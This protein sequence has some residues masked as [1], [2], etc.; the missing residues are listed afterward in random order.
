M[1]VI[2]SLTKAPGLLASNPVLFVPLFV[3]YLLSSI[4]TVSQSVAPLAGAI[5][6]LVMSGVLFFLGP[7]F[8]AGTI[9]MTNEAA[10]SS[11]TSLGTFVQDAKQHYVSVLG[12]YLGFVVI[13]IGLIIVAVIAG[14]IVAAIYFFV[15]D[16]LV[17]VALGA[18][19]GLA[20]GI[21]YFAIAFLLQF[22]A[23]A[24]VIEDYGAVDGLKR[25]VS[26]VRD[27]LLAVGGYF[28][29]VFAGGAVLTVLYVGL[30]W[31][32]P[33]PFITEPAT[34]VTLEIALLEALLTVVVLAPFGAVYLVYSVLFYR[35]LLGDTPVSNGPA[36]S[37]DAAVE[38]S[39]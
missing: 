35:T 3:L 39:I 8:Q 1:A 2:K 19:V 20:V 12:A 36:Q 4:Q 9:G 17:V 7:L 13:M 37:T 23:H 26:V 29:I 31:L 38:S 11:R 16:S 15:S 32:L 24:I 14:G 18:L 6:A 34:T 33:I 5:I 21:A 25:S 30:L 28:L 27:N 22:Y 10:T